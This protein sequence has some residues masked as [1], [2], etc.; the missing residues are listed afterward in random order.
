MLACLRC[1]C[2]WLARVVQH[3]RACTH[4]FRRSL[5][6]KHPDRERLCIF[7]L[8]FLLSLSA[9]EST[10]LGGVDLGATA[11]AT[12]AMSPAALLDILEWDRIER[13]VVVV[14]VKWG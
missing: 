6:V 2:A 5:Q 9:A 13:G 7:A 14:V 4:F 8:L 1:T 3:L 12:L 11:G 10:T